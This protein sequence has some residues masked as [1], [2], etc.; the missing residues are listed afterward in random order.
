MTTEGEMERVLNRIRSWGWMVAVHNDYTLNG[1]PHTFW[2]FT[3]PSSNLFVKGEGRFDI[4]ALQA[5]EL[6]IQRQANQDT[7]LLVA[8]RILQTDDGDG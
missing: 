6:E 5:V 3:N 8:L 4:D 1:V 7:T 2:L